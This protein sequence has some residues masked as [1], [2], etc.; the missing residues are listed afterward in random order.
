MRKSILIMGLY[1]L[2]FGLILPLLLNQLAAVTFR[3]DIPPWR[4]ASYPIAVVGLL[5][6]I[7]GLPVRTSSYIDASY[8]AKAY[9]YATLIN[10]IAAVVFI[11]PVLVPSLEFPILITRWPGIYMVTAYFSFIV[12]GIL[13]SLGWFVIYSNFKRLFNRYIF[14]K[15]SCILQFALYQIGIYGLAFF[16]FWGGYT[17]SALSYEGAQDAMVGIVMESTVIPSALF[18]YT[19]M[20]ASAIGVVTLLSGKQRKEVK[21]TLP[22][23]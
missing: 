9:L 20:F 6:V 3:G 19:I 12:V 1:L 16:M 22:S 23:R 15:E 2:L 8:I 18:I 4:T 14:D 17:G 10:M 7:I 21:A 11:T 5:L 13:G